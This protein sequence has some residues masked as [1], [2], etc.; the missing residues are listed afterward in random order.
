MGANALV[1]GCWL[2]HAPLPLPYP[3]VDLLVFAD[4]SL[5]LAGPEVVVRTGPL[6]PGG[7]V[8]VR[9]RPGASLSLGLAADEVPLDG[10]PFGHVEPGSPRD[11]LSSALDLLDRIPLCDNDSTVERAVGMLADEPSA[12]VGDLAA[13]VGLSQR[14]L[15]RRFAVAVGL[16]PKAY[17]RVVR[18]HAALR[19]AGTVGWAEIAQRCGF[20]DQSHMIAEFRVATGLAP[21]A[22]HGRFLQSRAGPERP[23]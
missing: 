11:R 15:R 19:L 18:L 13:A 14:Q 1:A 10:T 20:Y 9:L 6:P 5:R 17:G 23:G 2:D 8:G 21:A 3:A 22:L 16:S 7:L 12:R 4:G